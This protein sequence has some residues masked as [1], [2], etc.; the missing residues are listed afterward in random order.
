MAGHVYL[1][2]SPT[3]H[4]YKI[5]KSIDAAIR[6]ADLGI[7]LPFR[8]EVIAI[9]KVH[10]HHQTEKLLHEKYGKQRINGEWF[11]LHHGDV[12]TLI[13]DMS[14]V[15]V[16]VASGFS[17]LSSDSVENILKVK[18]HIPN[19]VLQRDHYTK[20]EKRNRLRGGKQAKIDQLI[21]ETGILRERIL[22][23]EK[24]V[25]KQDLPAV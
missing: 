24:L 4:W 12:R 15:Q 23:L 3:F 7:L 5:G 9:W 13:K 11:N 16:R 1:I 17:N 21:K 10:D 20:R 25:D 8:I 18:K 19:A 6:V 14:P 2:G 22:E